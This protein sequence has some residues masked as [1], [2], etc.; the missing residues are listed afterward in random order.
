MKQLLY[1]KKE[2][3]QQRAT[4]GERQADGEWMDWIGM[5][6]KTCSTVNDNDR[7]CGGM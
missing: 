5:S 4:E 7:E 3:T 6:V 2:R 1:G